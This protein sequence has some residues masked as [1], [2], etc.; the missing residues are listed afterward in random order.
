MPKPILSVGVQLFIGCWIMSGNVV[1]HASVRIS[2]PPP[3]L[4]I[5]SS[6]RSLAVMTLRS[7]TTWSWLASPSW[8]LADALLI[9]AIAGEME[10]SGQSRQSDRRPFLSSIL[11]CPDA[12]LCHRST[13]L[14]PPAPPCHW[15]TAPSAPQARSCARNRIQPR[16]LKM[17]SGGNSWG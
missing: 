17:F 15:L 16:K 1:V 12:Q 6:I 10:E 8:V 3:T 13:P 2:W 9:V 4:L 14:A 11:P 7:Q 5:C